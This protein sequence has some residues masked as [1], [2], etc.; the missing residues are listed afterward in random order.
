VEEKQ[1]TTGDRF[2][3][4]AKVCHPRNNPNNVVQLC[5]KIWQQNISL[6]ITFKLLLIKSPLLPTII[7]YCQFFDYR[8]LLPN[9]GSVPTMP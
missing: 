9:L 3:F 1:E 2:S 4:Q 7:D 5:F 8:R 6:S